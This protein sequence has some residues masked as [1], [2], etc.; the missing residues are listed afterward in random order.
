MFFV[1]L[2]LL[3][4]CVCCLSVLHSIFGTVQPAVDYL[5]LFHS[6]LCLFPNAS[7]MSG[8]LLPPQHAFYLF[9]APPGLAVF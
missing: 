5:L 1:L 6:P 8:M 4:V 3:C 9:G 2:T 7:T